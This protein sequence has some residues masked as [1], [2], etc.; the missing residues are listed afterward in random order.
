MK[1]YILF[2]QLNEFCYFAGTN[3][4]VYQITLPE[5]PGEEITKKKIDLPLPVKVESM[6]LH[7]TV[8]Y[9]GTF[10]H[11]AYLLDTHSGHIRSLAQVIPQVPVRTIKAS[12]DHQILIGTDGSG[13]YCLDASSHQL[14]KRYSSHDGGIHGISGNTISDLLVDERNRF[15]ISTSTNGVSILDPHTPDIRWKR[16]ESDNNQSLLSDHVNVIL[17]DSDGDMWYGTN[18]G[19]S[20]HLTKENRWT[21]F[22][23][24]H[25]DEID[26][27]PVIL[28]LCEDHEKNI[29]AGGFGTGGWKINKQK[30]SIQ[31]VPRKTAASDE[32][33]TSDYIYA[34]YTD[35]TSLFFGGIEGELTAY[36]PRTQTYTYYPV[37]CIGDI[38][39]G[40]NETLLL[41][42]CDGL[43]IIN[44][45]TRQLQ[46]YKEFEGE[47]L[48]CAV[49]SLLQT[50]PRDLF[51]ATDGKG[52]IHL[53]P[54]TGQSRH[55]TFHKEF[56]SH[57]IQQMVMDAQ[58][59]LWFSTDQNLYRLHIAS[60]E[61]THMNPMLGIQSGNFNPRAAYQ[62]KNGLF[63]IGTADGVMEFDPTFNM[64][65]PDS[66]H[67]VFTGLSLFHQ[68]LV[69][70][71]AS[72]LKKAI[73]ETSSLELSYNQNSFS[74]SF[75]SIQFSY[76]W[77]IEYTC[78]LEG[79]DKDWHPAS[80]ERSVSYTN[81]KPG[82]YT[83]KVRAINPYSPD[84]YDE[85]ELVVRIG[86]PFWQSGWAY[87]LY[88]CLVT[89]ITVLSIHYIRHKN[90][91]KKTQEKIRTFVEIAHNIRT[92]ISLIKAPLSEIE[93]SEHLS[94]AGKKFLALAMA[95]T[96]KL[97]T[98]V[99][100]LLDFQK[101]ELGNNGLSISGQ[102][103]YGYMQEKLN[104]FNIAAIRKNILFNLQ[105]DFEDLTVGLDVEKMDKI[106]NNILS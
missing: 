7:D 70:G 40:T 98:M 85:K 72:P 58:G 11:S 81:L 51:L 20:L 68:P 34:I 65:Q 83:L 37:D 90:K 86:K 88:S 56:I 54:E 32:G 35:G 84:H 76:P 77:Q 66:P 55:M 67:L 57:S 42:T 97:F 33:L 30:Q 52:L 82:H 63:V 22:L 87:L 8:L 9:I 92:P 94:G 38:L 2:T 78:K 48:G 89:L 45:E 26:Q 102:E 1:P 21:H 61:I 13:L 5:K 41:A 27:T 46:W 10:S 75:S 14:I 24:S 60:G 80:R 49:R 36:H 53:N 100:E 64:D 39:P 31:P 4:Q 91:E 50:S 15:W 59:D 96:E 44:K 3:Q 105:A 79:F 16:N 103:L 19:I 99:T 62:K 6:Y 25:P 28:A 106:L 104:T 69:A 43:A 23:Q 18:H 29:W 95:N 73:N 74:L 93:S 101:A 17:E 71:E 12:K 47:E